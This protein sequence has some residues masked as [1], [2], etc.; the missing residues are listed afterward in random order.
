MFDRRIDLA[1]AALFVAVM[2]LLPLMFSNNYLIGVLTV[3]VIYGLWS[4]S[5]DF[6]SGLTGRENFGHSLFIGVGAYTAGFLNTAW[7]L[8]AWWSLPA[9]MIVAAVFALAVGIPTLRLKGPYFALAMLSTAVIMQRLMLIFW[10]QTGGEEG[11]NGIEP[12][13]R[14]QLGFYYFALAVLVAVTAT[15]VAI[16]RSPWGLILR[17]IR[18]DEATCQAAGLNVT[19]YKIASLVISAAV[20]GAGG[21]MYAHYQLQVSPQVFAVVMSITIITMVYVGGMASIYGPVGGA[22]LLVLL[23]ELLRS[24]GEWRLMIYSCTLILIL[25]FLPEGF[26][27][28]VWRWIRARL[29]ARDGASR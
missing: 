22:I 11:I 18:G 6:M 7:G 10:E 26:I 25:F 16:A 4:V 8:P 14:S 19:F 1:G 13:I 2:A 12:L 23:T 17:A 24:F 5:W 15:L 9:A 29:G 27:A 3:S 21:A 20:A 28:P